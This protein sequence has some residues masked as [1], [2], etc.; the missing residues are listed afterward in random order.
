MIPYLIYCA[1]HLRFERLPRGVI[2]LDG[3]LWARPVP[4]LTKP[5]RYRRSWAATRAA[6][7][8]RLGVPVVRPV[9]D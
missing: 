7:R 8:A 2:H 4:A 1:E 5:R 9:E 3:E 6:W